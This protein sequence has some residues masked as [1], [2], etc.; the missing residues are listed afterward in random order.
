MAEYRLIIDPP[1]PGDW[2]MAVDE[3]LLADVAE[4][5]VGTVRF[6]QWDEPTLSLGYFQAYADRESHAASRACACV[7]RQS[8][9]GAIL[10]DR[11]LTYSLVLP[12]NHPLVRETERLYFEVH[13]A[14]ISLLEP[15]VAGDT[16][17]RL[18]R[19]AQE[20]T[21]AANEEPF[22]C[23]ERRARGDVVAVPTAV[24]R[25]VLPKPSQP[26]WKILGSAQRRHR[27]AVLQHGSLLLEMSPAAPELPGIAELAGV[28]L[29]PQALAEAAYAKI[30]QI[31]GVSLKRGELSP[32]LKSNAREIANNKY[33]AAGWT[34]RR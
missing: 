2:N 1:L 25:D 24:G 27:G 21:L 15:L 4:S 8:G 9:G 22:L 20:S 6:Y 3:A 31:L 19:N 26:D 16:A 30:A 7:R 28:R 14:F 12:A 29:D 34:N 33:G 10:H 5:G 11:E 32:V 17:P 23:F 13:D 18:T